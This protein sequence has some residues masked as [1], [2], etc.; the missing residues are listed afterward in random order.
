MI[1]TKLIRFAAT[2]IQPI[3]LFF[4]LAGFSQTSSDAVEMADT[5]RSNGKIYVVVCVLLII[6]TGL[7]IFLISIDRKVKRLE[8]EKEKK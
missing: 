8:K 5:M 1:S 3:F 4:P 6:F 2:L 7:S